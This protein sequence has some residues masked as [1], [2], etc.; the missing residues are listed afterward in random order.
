MMKFSPQPLCGSNLFKYSLLSFMILNAHAAYA[1]EATLQNN[2]NPSS[3]AM[4]NKSNT[5]AVLP[6]LKIE[7]MS[8]LDPIKSYVDYDQANVTRNGL[9]KKTFL[10]PSTPSMYRNIKS[11]ALT[12]SV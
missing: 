10:K 12:T 9:K 7:A 2:E 5:A 4:T 6:T 3:Q 1:D 11:M 8:E